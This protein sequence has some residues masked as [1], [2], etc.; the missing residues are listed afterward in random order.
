LA[1]PNEGDQVLRFDRS[2]LPERA[3]FTQEGFLRADAVLTRVG[4]FEYLDHDGS[5][6]RELRHPDDVFDPASLASFRLLPVTNT[7]PPEGRVDSKN[8]R[9]VSV[10][11]TGENVRQDG[12]L[13]R[14]PVVV[15]DEAGIAAVKRGRRFLSNG[16][17]ARIDEEVGVFE[18]EPYTHRQRNIRGNHVSI[19]DS[20]RAGVV[21]QIRLDGDGN[22]LTEG[23]RTMDPK[24]LSTV[25]L[26][27][28]S[29]EAAP[30]VVNALGK[31]RDEAKAL[32]ARLDAAEK[33]AK[34]AADKIAAE[35]DT[36]K[37]RLDKAEKVD[38]AGLVRARVALETSA[39]KILPETE[40]EKLDGMSDAEIRKA[41]VAAKWPELKLDDKSDA[42]IA[43]RHEIAVE[44]V[45]RVDADAQQRADALAAQRKLSAHRQDGTPP[46]DAAARKAEERIANQ[47]NPAW[48]PAA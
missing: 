5:V 30:E 3:E 4:V 24:K 32:Q 27:G 48:K 7:H 17:T 21:A 13:M 35:R 38:V 28:I 14:G 8:A 41:V 11:F 40:H 1:T 12:R 39:R 34:D 9:A 42:Y 26:D 46:A 47:W 19:V 16:Y 45:A 10:G 15:T 31:A 25:V 37:E 29:Y 6:R 2:E 22:Q 33:D 36:L 43:T 23:D 18:G 20:P 44:D